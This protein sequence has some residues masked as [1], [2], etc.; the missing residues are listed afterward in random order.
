MPK[1]RES[2]QTRSGSI[3]NGQGQRYLDVGQQ[4]QVSVLFARAQDQIRRSSCPN[5][6][7]HPSSSASSRIWTLQEQQLSEKTGTRIIPVFSETFQLVERALFTAA[8]GWAYRWERRDRESGI[9]W[10]GTVGATLALV[11]L[12][13]GNVAVGDK[14][15]VGVEWAVAI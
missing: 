15:G 8:S 9:G 14:V 1:F 3:R 5:N 4:A 7:P 6:V 11:S 13:A 2:N 12:G 10:S